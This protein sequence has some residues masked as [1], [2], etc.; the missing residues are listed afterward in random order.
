MGS[1]PIQPPSPRGVQYSTSRRRERFGPQ[2]RPVARNRRFRRYPQG[3]SGRE[4]RAGQDKHL[5]ADDAASS[6]ANPARKPSAAAARQARSGI[7]SL[8]GRHKLSRPRSNHRRI[9]S[10][11]PASPTTRSSSFEPFQ[12]QQDRAIFDFLSAGGTNSRDIEPNRGA[13]LNA[14]GSSRQGEGVGTPEAA[15]QMLLT[16]GEGSRPHAGKR[17]PSTSRSRSAPECLEPNRCL[18]VS[19]ADA[20]CA[21]GELRAAFE[22]EAQSLLEE[23][24]NLTQLLQEEVRRKADA[25][26]R[27]SRRNILDDAGDRYPMPSSELRRYG[28]KLEDAVR[29][30]EQAAVI[31][32]RFSL[33]RP[34]GSHAF[35]GASGV[36]PRR[37]GEKG[38]RRRGAGLTTGEGGGE[39]DRATPHSIPTSIGISCSSRWESRRHGDTSATL[40][41]PWESEG[42]D[43][44]GAALASRLRG[45]VRDAR[46]RKALLDDER[47]FS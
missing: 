44:R 29:S 37:G 3:R 33:A 38:D 6:R 1:R 32:E 18:S 7:S 17:P 47:F 46:N 21:L 20:S 22:E 25:E 13:T 15:R 35:A 14:K 31:S 34:G 12:S 10:S 16:R 45:V 9:I 26:R 36:I 27:Q 5:A 43:L 39:G 4:R 40:E 8:R 28:K 2:R 11:K 23:T 24:A 19:T 30:R 41:P 42:R